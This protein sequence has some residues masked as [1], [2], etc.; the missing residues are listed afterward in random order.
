MADFGSRGR[1]NEASSSGSV[2]DA[3][4][5]VDPHRLALA[6]DDEDQRDASGGDDVLQRVEAVVAPEIGDGQVVLVEHAH[7]ATRA[8]AR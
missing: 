8:A 4:R 2:A 3:R 6:G 1:S 7:V 5:A